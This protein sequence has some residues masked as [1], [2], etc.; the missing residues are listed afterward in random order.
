MLFKHPELLWA[1]F[2]LLIPIFIHLFQLRRFKKTPF[3]NVKILQ[4]VVAE[5][6]K[7]NSLKKW[8]LLLTRLLLLTALIVAFA[9]PIIPGK[10]ALKSNEIVIY[11]DNSLSMQ[12]KMGTGTLMEN[13]VQGLLKSIPIESTFSLFTNDK[14]F[15][16][17]RI[18]NIK[19]D[20]L[21]LPYSN[22]QLQLEEIYLK[23]KT[24]FS[25]DGDTRKDLVLVSDFQRRMYSPSKDSLSN[26][27]R[28]LVKST[29]ENIDNVSIDTVYINSI[30]SEN[31]DI[32]SVLSSNF[33][34]WT[35]L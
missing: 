3:T 18:E 25:E 31:L 10:S 27:N 24:L 11:L 29:P 16:E 23:A 7:S 30:S 33:R 21:S 4:K 15:K 12:A 17:V 35:Q 5:S 1:L 6:R 9:Q 2:L 32:K 28:H 22:N 8:L 20:L 34:C 13:M 14:L 19:N 26:V